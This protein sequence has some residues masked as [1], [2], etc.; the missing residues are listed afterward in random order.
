MSKMTIKEIR[1][2]NDKDLVTFIG[3]KRE[4]LRTL[5]FNA[6]GSGM[7]DGHAIGNVRKEIARALTEYN[8][9]G[10]EHTDA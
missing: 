9:R 1:E 2:K 3:E 5:R 8:R 6:S 7:R 4:E 10:S